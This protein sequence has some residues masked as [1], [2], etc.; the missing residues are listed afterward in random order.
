MEIT[1]LVSLLQETDDYDWLNFAMNSVEEIINGRETQVSK[2]FPDGSKI[3]VRMEGDR[4][5]VDMTSF[6]FD[7]SYSWKVERL[8]EGHVSL[9]NFKLEG[10][11]IDAESFERCSAV[12]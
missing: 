4:V 10:G 6:G 7:V 3:E 11:D 5:M 1:Y 2:T 12:L 8:A 9:V